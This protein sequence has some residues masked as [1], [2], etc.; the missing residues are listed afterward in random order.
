MEAGHELQ[1]T[2]EDGASQQPN[3]QY[4]FVT[5]HDRRTIRSR[6]MRNSW[7]Q[8]HERNS[9]RPSMRERLLPVTRRMAPN[10]EA[11]SLRNLPSRA[12]RQADL[13]SLINSV[14]LPTMKSRRNVLGCQTQSDDHENE[15]CNEAPAFLEMNSADKA[16]E[17]PRRQHPSSP[18][19]QNAISSFEV[20]T[21]DPFET[22]PA[23][24]RPFE[25]ALIH[26]WIH[27]F[28][29]MMF[30]NPRSS[31][32]P[33]TDVWIPEALSNE[34]SFQGMLSYAAAH[35]GHLSGRDSGV[36]GI[37]YK[38]KSIAAIQNL[39][40]NDE[41]MLSDN[42][43]AAVLR[44]ISI[45]DRF[46]SAEIASLHRAGL[47]KIMEKRGGNL[48]DNWR[49]DLLHHWYL[50]T[51]RPK[52]NLGD[53]T[54]QQQQADAGDK[55]NEELTT[56]PRH[57]SAIRGLSAK[58]PKLFD[59]FWE[60]RRLTT[61]TTDQEKY[62]RMALSS[63]EN[64]RESTERLLYVFRTCPGPSRGPTHD[65]IEETCRLAVLFYMAA[66]KA[67]SMNFGRSDFRLL[68]QLVSDTQ[69]SWEYS[70]EMLLWILLRGNGPG[71]A[72]PEI[73]RRVLSYMEVAKHLKK[74]SWNAVKEI[75]IGFLCDD[76]QKAI[77]ISDESTLF[78]ADLM[79]IPS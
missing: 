9:R 3:S 77:G 41:T 53:H 64:G 28:G 13:A 30:G 48:D 59:F 21:F 47:E 42:A 8:R 14:V 46:E 22:C 25:H 31:I 79:R 37:I 60:L 65:T 62:Y 45:E 34:A 39:L 26:H 38:I 11:S 10:Q 76:A 19:E 58:A 4:V 12:E 33:M 44:Q 54:F 75:L 7:S 71:L 63:V 18:N 15:T 70:L 56:A 17:E 1:S 32:N 23:T 50:L 6:L 2:S 55:D 24:I 43:V 67:D 51:S 20:A 61:S 68:L 57:A 16:S 49:L 5:D 72:N 66:I 74:E 27:V 35:L 78:V 36:Q 29:T 40:N 52:F 73:V 69:S